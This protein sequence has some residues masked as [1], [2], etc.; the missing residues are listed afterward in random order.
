MSLTGPMNW[1]EPEDFRIDA[2][3][4]VH[5]GLG[6]YGRAFAVSIAERLRVEG[7]PVLDVVP[8]DFGH[9][10]ILRRRPYLLW[11]GCAKEYGNTGRW[12]AFVCAQPNVL[13]HWMLAVQ[14]RA[15]IAR[16][17]ARL[18]EVLMAS[19]GAVELEAVA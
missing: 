5:A 17:Q 18:L 9:C 11:I 6:D 7:E 12:G 19:T 16:V 3:E 10:V 1:V 8:E 15:D 13:Q 14:L 4:D 2:R